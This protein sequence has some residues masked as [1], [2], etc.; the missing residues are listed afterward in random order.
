MNQ[1][2]LMPLHVLASLVLMAV[3]FLAQLVPAV[4]VAPAGVGGP[5]CP[6]RLIAGAAT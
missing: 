5:C 1:P 3:A 6:S 2:E 4:L